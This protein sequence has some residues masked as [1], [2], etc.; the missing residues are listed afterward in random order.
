M[1]P[2][3]RCLSNASQISHRSERMYTSNEL[4]GH[5]KV[6]KGAHRR[7]KPP[8]PTRSERMYSM[9]ELKALSSMQAKTSPRSDKMEFGGGQRNDGLASE[10]HMS[11]SSNSPP[12]NTSPPSNQRRS[13]PPAHGHSSGGTRASSS[14]SMEM[15]LASCQP[16]L[17][18]IAPVLAS[19][20]IRQEEHL[21]AMARLR[22]E[23]R[24]REVKEEVLKKGV[25][26]L[27]WAILM[28]RLQSL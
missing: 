17:L 20:G 24:D 21:R 26:V 16:T 7:A 11:R 8:S 18:H 25:S 27:E 10:M 13:S 9:A 3:R 12:R 28:D 1:S 19:L 6:P 4:S 23:T 15:I 14:S 5:Y 22:E 2:L